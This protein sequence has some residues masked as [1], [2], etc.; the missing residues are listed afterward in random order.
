[1]VSKL[2][3]EETQSRA[4]EKGSSDFFFNYG[5]AKGGESHSK[6]S[7]KVIFEKNSNHGKDKRDGKEPF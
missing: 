3:R 6:A 4:S 5:E 1:M 7:E 2:G